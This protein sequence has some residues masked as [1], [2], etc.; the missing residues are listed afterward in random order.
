MTTPLAQ[1]PSMTNQEYLLLDGRRSID[2]IVGGNCL[3]KL[4]R[5]WARAIVTGCL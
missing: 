4:L 3:R 5:R 2:E 1:T